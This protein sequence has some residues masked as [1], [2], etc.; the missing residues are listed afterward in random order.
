MVLLT[1]EAVNPG[2]TIALNA[3]SDVFESAMLEN[4]GENEPRVALRIE[5]GRLMLGKKPGQAARY[6]HSVRV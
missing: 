1:E 3:P 5:L 6:R 2:Q 4:A